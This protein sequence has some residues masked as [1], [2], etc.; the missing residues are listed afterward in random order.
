MKAN[1]RRIGLWI[2]WLAM[3]TLALAVLFIV[4]TPQGRTGFHTA[5]FVSQMLDLPVKPQSWF[6]DEPLRQK[7]C[8]S[9][10]DDALGPSRS[11]RWALLPTGWTTRP[12]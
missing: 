9:A 6:T 12:S 8:H 2:L 5:L 4:A 1:L 11:C 10:S 3:A 7:V